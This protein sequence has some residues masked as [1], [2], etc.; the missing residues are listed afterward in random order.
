M[1]ALR[2]RINEINDEHN[3]H[4]DYYERLRSSSGNVTAGRLKRSNRQRKQRL[5]DEGGG[6]VVFSKTVNCLERMRE[7]SSLLIFT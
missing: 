4:G 1:S 5:F 2:D 6:N 3:L 7:Y